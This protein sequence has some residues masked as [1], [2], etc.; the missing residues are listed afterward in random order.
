MALL[1]DPEASWDQPALTAFGYLNHALGTE[2]W[3]YIGYAMG[4]GAVS[5]AMMLPASTQTFS[6]LI[7]PSPY[8]RGPLSQ[9]SM[10]FQDMI[11]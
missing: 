2:R 11:P 3:R 5:Y 8:G 1:K 7:N 6:R 4:T 10:Q 9:N